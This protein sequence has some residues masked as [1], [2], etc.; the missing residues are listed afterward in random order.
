MSLVRLFIRRSLGASGLLLA[1]ASCGPTPDTP[2]VT[3]PTDSVAA[4]LADVER[5]ITEAPTAALFAERA[6]LQERRDSVALAVSDWKRAIAMDSTNASYHVGLGDL[7]Y[8]TIR[9]A[10]AEAELRTAMR[11]APDDTG[12][13]LK[14][15]EMK[16]LQREYQQAMDLA[17]EALRLEPVHAKGYF[18]KGWIYKETGDTNLAISS[19]RTAAEQD[20][21]FIDPLLELGLLHAERRDPLAL[22]YFNS[23]LTVRPNSSDALYALGMYAQENGMDSLAVACYGRMKETAPGNALP[24]YNTGYILL[25]HK[26]EPEAAREEFTE[27]IR[28]SPGYIE[29]YYNRGL[30]YEEN[31]SLD[32]ALADF[33]RALALDPTF[34]LA[35]EGLGRLADRGVHVER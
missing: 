6:R 31:G 25:V 12:P 17:N 4:R 18:L 2:A 14:L 28:R 21:D 27:A 15:A 5:R 7:Y 33:K 23:A 30:T 20:P 16:L 9:L 35:A 34:T 3:I 19:Y 32:S 1:L 29:A 10:E 13:K 11:I 24:W 22:Q 8:R 26:N